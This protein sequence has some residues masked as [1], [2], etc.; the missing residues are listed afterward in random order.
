M[1][2]EIGSPKKP[3]G[4]T[5][6]GTNA[7]RDS[8]VADEAIRAAKPSV[9]RRGGVLAVRIAG[10]PVKDRAARFEAKGRVAPAQVNKTPASTPY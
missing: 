4:S 7:E 9:S 10:C 8:M 6:L 5:G 3:S 1:R 2:W